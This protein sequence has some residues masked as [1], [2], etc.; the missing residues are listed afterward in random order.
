MFFPMFMQISYYLRS[1]LLRS[2]SLA[3]DMMLKHLWHHQDAILCCS[4]KVNCV[5]TDPLV[6]HK[7]SWKR[8][9]L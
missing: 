2:D 7:G 3:G 1:D 9:F 8:I 6:F 4:L 5:L